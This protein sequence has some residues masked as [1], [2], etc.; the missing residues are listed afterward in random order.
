MQFSYIYY[1]VLHRH[2][3]C[4][5]AGLCLLL[6][7]GLAASFISASSSR[8]TDRRGDRCALSNELASR[9][10]SIFTRII[11]RK[12]PATILYEDEQAIAFLGLNQ[13][14]PIQFLVVPKKQL[15]TLEEAQDCD[16][17]LLGHLFMVARRVAKQ[18][19][20]EHGYR[21]VLNNGDDAL[22]AVPHLHMHVFAGQTMNWPPG[23][24]RRWRGGKK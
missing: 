19:G 24:G 11:Q 13:V 14:V 7:L 22:Q 10:P 4:L 18:R 9:R 6:L 2:S 12:A 17:Q 15:A 1:R 20:V 3:V 16:E 23:T 21:M 5:S 8:Y